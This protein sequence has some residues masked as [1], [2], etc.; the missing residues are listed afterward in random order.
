MEP[1]RVIVVDDAADTRFLI[2]LVLGDAEG[3]EVVAEADSADAALAAMEAGA[4]PHVALV[5]ARMPAV[6]GY[7]LTGMLRQRFPDVRVAVLTS[8][9]DEVVEQQARDAGAHAC[10]LK[11]D[12]ADLGELVLALAGPADGSRA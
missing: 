6:D 5:D 8:M 3:V 12:M 11:A 10:L 1:V 4:R 7:E 9:V 2:G